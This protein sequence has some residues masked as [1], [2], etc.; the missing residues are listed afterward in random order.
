MPILLGIALAR[1][2]KE[3]LEEISTANI[4]VK[5]GIIGDRRGSSNKR[6]VTV[7]FNMDW[8]DTCKELGREIHWTNRRANL[9]V[10]DIR[11]Y[12][13]SNRRI[14][15]GDVILRVN[16]ETDPCLV[17]N[18]QYRGLME[19]LTP[20]WRGGVCCSVIKGGTINIGDSIKID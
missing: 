15:I 5:Q 6:Q 14:L 1:N 7:L 20:N 18:T 16:F 3:K 10:S 19:A 2:K 4:T 13:C 8:L 12:E 9:Y 11:A 17:M